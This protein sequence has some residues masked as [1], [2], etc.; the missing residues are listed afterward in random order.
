MRNTVVESLLVRVCLGVRFA[1]ALCDDLVEAIFVAQV[2]AVL[3]LHAGS[4]LEELATQSAAHDAV[5]LLRDELMA[6]LFHDLFLP[7]A[8]STLTVEAKVKGSLPLVVFR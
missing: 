1:D 8:H 2:L 6:V 5:E 4:I 3:T 7:L